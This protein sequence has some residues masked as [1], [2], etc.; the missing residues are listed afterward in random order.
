MPFL[1]LVDGALRAPAATVR[2][3]GVARRVDGCGPLYAPFD[4]GTLARR[5]HRAADTV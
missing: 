2:P 5:A 1:A 3:A 4:P